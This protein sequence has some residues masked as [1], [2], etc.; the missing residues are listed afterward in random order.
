MHKP[1]MS[2]GVDFSLK[3]YYV[4]IDD[5]EILEVYFADAQCVFCEAIGAYRMSE[6][7][8]AFCEKCLHDNYKDKIR[9]EEK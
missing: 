3:N 1:Q 9:V 7:G 8:I 4:T 6:A 5:E 2:S